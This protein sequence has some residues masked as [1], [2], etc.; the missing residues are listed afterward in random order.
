MAVATRKRWLMWRRSFS[1][2]ARTSE[3]DRVVGLDLV[4]TAEVRPSIRIEAYPKDA[5]GLDVTA[6]FGRLSVDGDRYELQGLPAGRYGLLI[7]PSYELEEL[8]KDEAIV[9]HIY[10]PEVVVAE[11]QVVMRDITL[12][13]VRNVSI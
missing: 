9:P 5:E 11:G 7:G 12:P 10:L 2:T 1:T 8:S 6:G 13:S 3:S 4:R